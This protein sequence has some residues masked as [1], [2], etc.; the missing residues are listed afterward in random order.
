MM[1]ASYFATRY[2]PHPGRMKVWRAIC[3]YLQKFI[4][5]SSVVVD[6]GCGYCDFI[7]QIAAAKKYAVDVHD[8]AAKSCWPEVEFVK[9]TALE[10]LELPADSVDVVLLSNVLEHLWPQQT[11]ALLD[12]LHDLLRS[13]GTLII[14]QPNYF[15]C[16]R[17][18]WDDFTHV[19][20]FSHVSLTDLLISRR[21]RIRAVEKRFLPFSFKSGLPKSYWLTKLYLISPWRPVAGQMLVVARR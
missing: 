3:E 18:Y 11:E 19:R 14:I 6:V 10:E 12:R 7:N 2:S 20:A 13:N 1:E 16:Y 15:Y 21:Y 5:T 4:P 9:T 8:E 17:H